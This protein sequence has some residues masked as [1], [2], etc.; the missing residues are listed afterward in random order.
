MPLPITPT[1]LTVV[2]RASTLA[3]SRFPR[4]LSILCGDQCTIQA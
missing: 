2:T 3:A 4:A 1:Q